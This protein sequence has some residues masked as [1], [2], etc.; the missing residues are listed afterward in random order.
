MEERNI[1]L[2]FHEK[3]VSSELHT[4]PTVGKISISNKQGVYIIYDYQMKVLHVGKT[5]GARNGIDQRLLDHISN[6]SSFSKLYMKPNKIFLRNS[7]KFKFVEIDDARKRSLV[8]ALTAG[9][10][11]PLHIGT[12]E[13][14][15]LEVNN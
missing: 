1:V 9:L 12:G 15:I 5:N 14:K 11:C 13:K 3:L 7:A 2:K 10:L 6:R 8:E 4:I